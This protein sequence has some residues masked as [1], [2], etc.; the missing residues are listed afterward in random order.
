MFLFY[1]GKQSSLNLFEVVEKILHKYDPELIFEKDHTS[2]TRVGS[3]SDKQGHHMEFVANFCWL[4]SKVFQDASTIVGFSWNGGF[5][6]N[7]KSGDMV[8]PRYFVDIAKGKKFSLLFLADKYEIKNDFQDHLQQFLNSQDARLIDIVN[9]EFKSENP[10]K[11]NE[12][13]H[14]LES[15]DF[16]QNVTLLGTWQILEPSQWPEKVVISD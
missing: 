12:Q 11:A 9:S 6:K 10:L 16:Y 1:I 14:F 5:N 15:K 7:Y 13:A 2:G 8:I 3:I 4:N